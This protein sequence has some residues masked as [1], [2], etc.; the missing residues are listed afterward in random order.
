MYSLFQRDR[1]DAP[2]PMSMLFYD[3]QVSGQFWDGLA[4]DGYFGNTT[5]AW[6]S[7][8]SSW[9]NTNGLYVAM[10]CE[11]PPLSRTADESSRRGAEPPDAPRY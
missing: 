1:S 3:P 4:L 2:E 11:F 8:R 7:M 5:D 10:K 9:T 6:V